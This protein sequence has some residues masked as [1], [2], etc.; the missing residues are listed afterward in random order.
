MLGSNRGRQA[1]TGNH[2]A[3]TR[4]GHLSPSSS[5]YRQPH[6]RVRHRS[7][8]CWERGGCRGQG[9]VVLVRGLCPHSCSSSVLL[10]RAPYLPRL[11]PPPL[12]PAAAAAACRRGLWLL[13]LHVEGNRFGWS[14]FVWGFSSGRRWMAEQAGAARSEDCG[15]LK[16]PL[17]RSLRPCSVHIEDTL[18]AIKSY[19]MVP[20]CRF[21]RAIA[22]VF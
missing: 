18:C 7:T 6:I 19:C 12:L 16:G 14:L 17:A 2:T 15:H 9:A 21:V 13:F 20:C 22:D 4:R 5:A 8:R 3:A 11:G 10:R 1:S